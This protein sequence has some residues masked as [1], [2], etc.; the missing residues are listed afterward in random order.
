M[1]NANRKY[2][3][4]KE[5]QLEEQQVEAKLNS[6]KRLR[7]NEKTCTVFKGSTAIPT[8]HVAFDPISETEVE[9][10]FVEEGTPGAV[11]IQWNRAHTTATFSFGPVLALRP[12]LKIEPGVVRIF[13]VRLDPSETGLGQFIITLSGSEVEPVV[14]YE[15]N[16][17]KREARIAAAKQTNEA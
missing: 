4:R 5:I 6:Q 16:K 3:V 17:K 2:I 7:L 8:N 10:V 11:K 15:V 12:A 9:V 14:D 1:P 13:Q